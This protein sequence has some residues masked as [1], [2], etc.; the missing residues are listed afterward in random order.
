MVKYVNPKYKGKKTKLTARALQIGG[1][2]LVTFAVA[3]LAPLAP[4]LFD[5]HKSKELS[6]EV[7]ETVVTPAED[8]HSFKDVNFDTLKAINKDAVGWIECEGT[9][10]DYAVV[11]GN[12]NDY[13]LHHSIN[14]EESF[15]GTIFMDA[16][17]NSDFKDDVTVLYG[18]NMR[19][20]SMFGSLSEYN[21][22][23]YYDKHS[24][25][26][27]HTE[28]SVYEFDL[29]AA[30]NQDATTLTVGNYSNKDNFVKAMNTIKKSSSFDS[31]VKITENSKVVCLYTCLD[32]G[33]NG[34][35]NRYLV[36][37]TVN[38]VLDKNMNMESSKTL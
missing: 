34:T 21:K 37:G 25:M 30:V 10:I 2:V 20:D 8:E 22:Q 19:N 4:N 13:Y 9:N 26:Y 29:F 28:D 32:S 38:K 11:Q 3:S 16:S 24:K 14:K 12:D 7:A 36:Y 35:N 5:Y 23:S 1:A 27:Y 6:T 31:D 33:S 15:S 18:H 17:N